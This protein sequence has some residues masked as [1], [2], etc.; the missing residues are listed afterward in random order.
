MFV[1][2]LDK[3][4]GLAVSGG[5]DSMAMLHCYR[6]VCQKMIVINIEHGIRGEN[7]QKDSEFVKEYCNTWEIPFLSFSIKTLEEC[8]KTKESTESA[9]RR[10]RYEIFDSLLAQKKVDVI[11]LAHHADDNTETVLMRIFRGTGIKGLRGIT[12]RKGFIRPLI[13]YTRAEIEEYVAQ[14]DIPFIEDETNKQSIY[15]RNFIRL[16]IIPKIKERYGEVTKVV[17]RLCDNAKEIDDYLLSKI[18]EITIKNK[19]CIIKN[20]FEKDTILQKYAVRE[21]FFRLGIMQD[22]EARHIESIVAL[23]DKENNTAID[24]PFFSR[25]VRHNNDLI[26]TSENRSNEFFEELN[27]NKIYE[28]NG[29]YYRFEIG[30]HI[31]KGISFDYDKVPKQ[32]VIRNWLSGDTFKRVNGKTK[33]VSDFLNEQKLSKIEK[34]NILVLANQQTILAILGYETS[35]LIKVD[36][37]TKKIIHIIKENIYDER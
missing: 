21:G 3:T 12:E 24:M 14:N 19:Q 9:A 10:L 31:A 36:K 2:K 6:L 1:E 32:A 33:L 8:E 28:H 4:V 13:K 7:S 37:T 16:E 20:L 18:G 30:E 29:Y 22:V 25:A 26:I 27:I 35:D 11:A 23:K 15:T 5:K 34:E 17:D